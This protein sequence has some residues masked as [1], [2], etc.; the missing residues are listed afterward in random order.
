DDLDP[1]KTLIALADGQRVF[2][3]Y[4]LKRILG[5]GG[6]GVVWLARDESLNRDL[7][8]KFLP[9]LVAAD[10][11]AVRELKRETERSQQLSHAH[12]LR[13]YDFVEGDGLCG[14]TMELVEGGTLSQRR[15]QQPGEIFEVGPLRPWLRQLCEALAYAHEDERIVHSDLKP[16]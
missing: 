10:S 9:Q 14:I 11:A 6:M 8:I 5:R 16:S 1:D 3:R 13:T 4:T 2:S 7:A 15:L 12:I